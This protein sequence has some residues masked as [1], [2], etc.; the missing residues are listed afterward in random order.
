M[1]TRYFIILLCWIS[2]GVAMGQEMSLDSCRQSLKRALL[3]GNSDSVA[4]AYCHFGEYY[5]YRNYDSARYYNQ[6]GLEAIRSSGM[7]IS[8]P[9]RVSLYCTLLINIADTYFADGNL[10]EAIRRNLFAKKEV[11]RLR[12]D[13]E[14]HT[15]ILGTLGGL[16][17]RCDKP[18]SALICYKEALHLL[19][20]IH[21]PDEKI[22]ILTNM[23][24]LYAN[25]QRL[26][27]GEF[28]IREAMKLSD[29]CQDMDM[30]M[31]AGATA[32]G[33]LGNLGKYEEA[34]KYL[35][36]V[37][38]KGRKEQKPRI[39]LKSMT[40][41]LN[42]YQKMDQRDSLSVYLAEATRLAESLPAANTEVQGFLQTQYQLLSYLG[43][44]RESIAVQR[45]LLS[46]ESVN[47]QVPKSVIYY[48][49]AQNYV[50][51][52]EFEKATKYYETAHA[53][54]DSLKQAELDAQLSE[55]TV[56]YKTQEKEMEIVRLRQEQLE[57]KARMLQWGMFSVVVVFILL[58][59]LI[60]G[61]VRRNQL[62]KAEE[63]KVAKSY[64]EGLERERGRLAKDLHDGVCN[65]LL[66][67]GMQLSV[68]P[69][70]ET[71][72]QEVLHLLENVRADVRSISHELMPP[73]F[74]Y[75][76]LLQTVKA[77][78]E[79]LPFK[80]SIQVSFHSNEEAH[81]ESL[82]EAVSYEVY[83]I[84]QEWLS[85]VWKY[86]QA[87]RVDICLFLEKNQLTLKIVNDGKSFQV[88]P[89]AGSGIGLATIQ[90][91]V[92]SING[93]LSLYC[94]DNSQYLEL[95]VKGL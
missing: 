75:L 24:I 50:A 88:T 12:A 17:R 23:A 81:W 63:L 70:D 74:Q 95:I 20:T 73:Q 60:Y 9:E 76:T 7:S 66:G 16:Y 67:I 91:R 54:S 90:E 30:V 72:K 21:K 89:L 59:V 29:E 41:L 61:R 3:A 46:E 28:Y 84:L 79:R 62:K 22:F 93:H 37:L 49:L 38:A 82:S 19:E 52:K 43:R 85:N 65:D 87:S 45:K 86:A 44:Y 77:Y 48:H 33:I 8:S 31:Y 11:E 57:N 32:G 42:Q 1:K 53:Q 55:W 51:L 27:E 47:V 5:A 4:T 34:V 78:L 36:Q 68:L 14:Y 10:E 83:R 92:K 25:T 6:K 35:K 64:I 69:P 13:V 40:Y 39:M 56:K 2:V 18:D 71:S 58:V 94:Q 15:T 80:E 26:E